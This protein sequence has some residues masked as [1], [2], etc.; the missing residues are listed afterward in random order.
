MWVSSLILYHNQKTHHYLWESLE[1]ANAWTPAEWP[2]RSKAR[3]TSLNSPPFPKQTSHTFTSGVKPHDA[4]NLDTQT[5]IKHT[6][7]SPTML[8]KINVVSLQVIVEGWDWP[9]TWWDGSI[10]IGHLVSVDRGQ[11]LSFQVPDVDG[12]VSRGTHDEFACTE[13]MCFKLDTPMKIC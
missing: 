1:K 13:E 5:N 11:Y 3:A 9:A 6:I 10:R 2:F 7:K 4:T 8:H 12:G